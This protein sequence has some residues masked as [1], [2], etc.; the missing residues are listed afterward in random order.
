[1]NTLPK[2]IRAFT[3]IELLIVVAII[4]ILA[5]IA[6]PNFLEAQTRAKVSRVKSDLRTLATAMEAYFV[7]NNSYVKDSDSSL[8]TNDVGPA[9]GDRNA[10]EFALAANGLLYLTS[11]ISYITSLPHDPFS[12]VVAVSGAGAISYRVGSGSWSYSAPPINTADHQD[13]HVVF[14]ITGAVHAWVAIGVGPD[15]SRARMGYKCFPFMPANNVKEGPPS[16]ALN[17]KGQPFCYTD[18]DPSNGTTSIGD[19]Y[20]FGGAVGEGRY[21]INGQTVGNGNSLGA[22][23]Y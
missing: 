20:R 4:S 18:Y 19:V 3:L 23:V 15:G 10:P 1:M 6:V 21:M 17:S 2:P 13:S 9:A 22:G 12:N 5:A 16:T 14:P 7:D 11:P 8:D